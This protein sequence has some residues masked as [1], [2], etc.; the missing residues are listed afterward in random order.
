MAKGN[1]A[2]AATAPELAAAAARASSRGQFLLVVIMLLTLFVLV[3]TLIL[4]PVL[5]KEGQQEAIVDYCKWTLAVLL[6]AFGA[7]IGAGA[8]YFFGKENLA[9]SS[10]STAEALRIQLQALRPQAHRIKD[11]PLSTLDEEFVFAVDST[12]TQVLTKLEARHGFWWVPVLDAQGKIYDVVHARV[13]WDP[14]VDA[15]W[16]IS[17]II[18]HLD[19]DKALEALKP[20][21]GASFF[22]TVMLEDEVNDAASLM[23][24]TKAVVGI[25]KDDSGKARFCFSRQDMDTARRAWESSPRS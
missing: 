4:V 22:T 12:K 23:E 18:E 19:T 11:L 6:G 5:V 3:L 25:V 16:A 1:G 14:K 10:R 15:G 9:E 20:L 24:R 13:F 17:D 2:N 7:W 8:A 21:H